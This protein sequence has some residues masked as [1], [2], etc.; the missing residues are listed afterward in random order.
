MECCLL[1]GEECD[2]HPLLGTRDHRGIQEMR[3]CSFVFRPRFQSF[4]RIA[5]FERYLVG[6]QTGP[7]L[8]V[9]TEE[10]DA[11]IDVEARAIVHSY[12]N[13]MA[14]D[15]RRRGTLAIIETRVSR[16]PFS[17]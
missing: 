10:S 15:R 2:A 9:E 5:G 14:Q 8:K 6:V 17:R 12:Y 3:W 1:P 7:W 16:V 13:P 11:L 4:Y